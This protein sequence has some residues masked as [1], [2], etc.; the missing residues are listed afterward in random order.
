MSEPMTM[1]AMAGFGL[2]ALGI[3]LFAALKGWQ[4]WLDLKRLELGSARAGRRATAAPPSGSSWRT[5]RSASASSKASPPASICE[6]R[7][8]PRACL[9]EGDRDAK[10]RG[11]GVI[12]SQI[13]PPP[14]FAWSP[15]PSE[16]GE[17]LRIYLEPLRPSR[18]SPQM[19][20]VAIIRLGQRRRPFPAQLL[21]DLRHGVAVADDQHRTPF[22]QY[23][24]DQPV[25]IAWI[26][27]AHLHPQLP[28]QRRRRLIGAPG[29]ADIDT[30]GGSAAN[31]PI[32]RRALARPR[33]APRRILV[34]PP[35]R[36]AA[37]RKSSAPRPAAGSSDRRRART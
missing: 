3:M 6:E 18:R 11:G 29:G 2:A 26:V 10:R 8:P 15:S 4:G 37:S 16:L 34:P 24:P 33:L 25:G 9:G 20:D 5:S 21:D 12:R 19:P 23:P 27:A 31:K 22:S 13:A 30:R 7:I 14:G 1:M 36:G 32:S 28:G 35:S 17:D